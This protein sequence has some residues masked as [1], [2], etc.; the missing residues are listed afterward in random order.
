MTMHHPQQ[1][2]PFHIA[3]QTIGGNRK[4]S[5]I[6]PPKFCGVIIM[7]KTWLCA[8]VVLLF[9]CCSSGIGHAQ[10][11]ASK[12]NLAA[13]NEFSA[14]MQD[15]S[16][17]VGPSVVQV[18]VRGY[19]LV[20]GAG[21]GI[22]ASQRGSGSGIVLDPN[23]FILTNGHV[24]Q[25]AQ[26]VKVV[27]PLSSYLN[28]EVTAGDESQGRMVDAKVIGTDPDSDLAVLKIEVKGLQ[29]L[30]L[31]DSSK[32]HQG[33][34]VL[35]VGSPLGL[36]NSASM[37][38][39][40]SVARQLKPE[41]PMIYIQTDAPI[42]PGNS[43][44]PLVDTNGR[45]I[46]INTM[47]FSQS[48]GS[49]GLGFSIPSN[50]A[51][52]IYQQ[53]RENGHVH[54]GQIGVQPRTITPVLA[55]GLKL[56]SDWGVVL[57][58]VQPDGP[59]DQAG[60]KPGDIV[61]TMDG[62]RVENARRMEVAIH[63]HKIGDPASVEVLRNGE[64]ITVSVPVIE[65]PNDPYRFADLVTRD[66]NLLPRMG[67]FVLDLDAILTERLPAL[68]KPAAVMV[69]ARVMDM[70]GLAELFQVGDLID[71]LN[72]KA[73]ANLADLRIGIDSLKSGDPV[74]FQIQRQGR[75]AYI[76]FEMP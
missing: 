43:G 10:L 7:K 48:G 46:G 30:E 75:L 39:I 6:D 8:F 63:Q 49:E 11:K 23:G 55:A 4:N 54:R 15:L 27:L 67:I 35:A 66:N 16:R 64:K 13:L 68:R 44:G 50:I 18:V 56:A 19:A 61:L 31:G 2:I 59:A 36:E 41:D 74:V 45:V 26:K 70:A 22:M 33:Q 28:P 5:K 47:I 71:T 25:G 17:Q 73:V 14:A 62:A 9:G 1:R 69:A 60:L 65:R 40:S 53:L 51:R 3:K 29:A 12:R 32:L 76:E 58:D 21:E 34:V 42:N 57:E 24:V 38:V 20:P 37:G 52:H 72:G